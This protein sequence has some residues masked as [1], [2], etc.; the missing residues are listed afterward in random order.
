MTVYSD[1]NYVYK[2]EAK[3]D[4]DAFFQ[5]LN[6]PYT[7]SKNK[8]LVTV[9]GK[10]VRAKVTKGKVVADLQN[11]ATAVGAT[12]VTYHKNENL[13]YV[14]VLPAGVV[15]I[16]PAVPKMGEHW[17]N[18]KDLPMGPIYGVYN[19]KL[20]FLEQMPSQEF[21]I[22]G[23]SLVD[24]DGMRGLPSPSI[25][26]TDIEFQKNGHE[27]YTVPHYDIHHYFITQKEQDAINPTA[28]HGH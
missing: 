16:T 14:L 12:K 9:N 21:F 19:G 26:Q 22:K 15:Q 10:S 5:V 27:G 7:F 6:Q 13:Y 2:N 3:V 17:A 1:V 18:P 24:L 25:V 28:A 4:V 23:E 8:N 20:V 11:L